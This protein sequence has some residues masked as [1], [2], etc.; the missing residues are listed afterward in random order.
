MA[1]LEHLRELLLGEF[2]AAADSLANTG[3][4]LLDLALALDIMDYS[5]LSG[6]AF[7]R[8]NLDPLLTS[9]IRDGREVNLVSS[10][11]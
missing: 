8:K 4:Y 9:W 2:D 10:I 6:A 5:V 1:H 3:E 7:R 11:P